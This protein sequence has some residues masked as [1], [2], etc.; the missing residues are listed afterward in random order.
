MIKYFSFFVGLFN[1]L[2]YRLVYYSRI[3]ARGLSSSFNGDILLGGGSDIFIGRNFRS[4]K[5]CFLNVSS[6]KLSF[7][8]NV[9]LNRDVSINCHSNISVGDNCL[10]GEGVKIYDHDHLFSDH[11]K[12]IREQGFDSSD[13]FIGKNVWIGSNVIVL[14]GVSIGDNSV[15]AAGSIVR[16]SVPSDTVFVQKRKTTLISL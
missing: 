5:N 7:G 6:G 16:E 2:F 4:R 1:L 13:I 14:K 3:N 15:I 10:F 12:P 11:S 9:F 8:D